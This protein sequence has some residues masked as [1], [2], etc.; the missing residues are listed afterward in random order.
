[1]KHSTWRVIPHW[2]HYLPYSWHVLREY[3][4]GY[5]VGLWEILLGNDLESLPPLF[6]GN[7]TF[8]NHDFMFEGWKLLR[9]SLHNSTNFIF[10]MLWR[11]YSGIMQKEVH[12]TFYCFLMETDY[13]L[14][15][16]IALPSSLHAYMPPFFLCPDHKESTCRLLSAF[17]HSTGET[18]CLCIPTASG[19]EPP[20]ISL[21]PLLSITLFKCHLFFTVFFVIRNRF[22]EL[23]RLF[24]TCLLSF[25]V[26]FLRTT[27]QFWLM[28]FHGLGR[29]HWTSAE[30][31]HYI[32]GSLFF[33]GRCWNCIQTSW[34][35]LCY[36]RRSATHSPLLFLPAP[37]MH[38]FVSNQTENFWAAGFLP[39]HDPFLTS[40]LISA[41]TLACSTK[42]S[43]C[44][45]AGW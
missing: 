28:H 38:S 17:P 9:I 45:D 41:K 37:E 7:G 43:S 26:A 30:L 6:V 22:Y 3:L 11:L 18:H 35:Q 24:Q 44:R 29:Q 1:M 21:T 8:K 12:E 5:L 14:S 2:T 25:T 15:G 33:S 36:I 31:Q 23:G 10:P 34:G 20:W 40:N 27:M 39:P 13:Y 19:C 16:K 42:H 4:F 32:T